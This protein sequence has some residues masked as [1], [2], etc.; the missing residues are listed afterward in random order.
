MVSRR[1]RANRSVGNKLNNLNDRVTQQQKTQQVTGTQTNAVTNGSIAPNA[2]N[3]E[4]IADRAVTS[5]QIGTGEVTSE[6]LGALTEIVAGGNLTIDAGLDG[7]LRLDGT[8]Y[9]LPY[10]GLDSGNGLYTVAFDP[11]DNAIKILD[12]TPTAH[13][14]LRFDTTYT[15]GSTATGMLSWSSTSDTLETMLNSSTTLQHGQETLVRVV[16]TS[17]S[18]TIPKFRA[19][20]FV[21]ESGGT[22]G[23]SLATASTVA[24]NPNSLIGI[25]TQAI[26]PSSVGF[27][28]HFGFISDVNTQT[29]SVGDYLYLNPTTT[30]G[31]LTTT[32]P[33]GDY[34]NTP[35]AT[36]IL[37]DSS[38]GRVFVRLNTATSAPL[39]GNYIINGAF[40]IWQRGTTSSTTAQYLADRWR[41]TRSVGTIT[42]SRSTTVPSNV[43]VQYSLSF[44]N[45]SGTAPTL[46]Q[47]IESFD[48]IQFA[49]KQ[50]TLSI[51]ARS[52]AGTSGLS[53]I[54]AYPTAVDNWTSETSDQTGVFVASDGTSATSMPLNTW[55]RYTATFTVPSAATVGYAV[56][57]YRNSAATSTTTLYAGAQLELGSVAT[58][59]R[60]SA[61]TN[62]AELAAC[63]RYYQRIV[64]K[65][66]Y[67]FFGTGVYNTSTAFFLPIHLPVEL[68]TT[69]AFSYGGALRIVTD[70]EETVSS[71]TL[72]ASGTTTNPVSL[73]GVSSSATADGM[74]AV[75]G[76]LNDAAAYLEFDSEL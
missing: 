31:T 1:Y 73:N 23:V 71:L 45:P 16:N 48:A 54:T 44:D 29:Y 12:A 49:G 58:P 33:S 70:N 64:A 36:V 75:L 74:A 25:T 50:V 4:S 19:V 38:A 66:A 59:F 41:H 47:R 2:V 20:V 7:H 40:D 34:F 30:T 35:L 14:G 61:P 76:A 22:A 27:V 62:Q 10:E 65:Q 69:P 9:N 52:S 11:A 57:I 13:D 68:R 8:S 60:R 39:S 3:S 32:R 43:G 24:S 28:T 17:A 51:W 53:W 56:K 21:G 18:V 72:Y 42:V 26:A 63:Q 67:A 6:N 55:I 5:R 37:V 15:G 46:T